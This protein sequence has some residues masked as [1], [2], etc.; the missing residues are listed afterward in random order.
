MPHLDNVLI[1][2]SGQI[3]EYREETYYSEIGDP[4]HRHISQLVGL[5]PGTQITELNPEWIKASEYTLNARGDESTGWSTM[6]RLLAWARIKN[7]SRA[8]DLLVTFIKNNVM[9]NLWDKHP[10][11]QIDGNFGYVAGVCEM[12]VQS[13]EGFID[14]LPTLSPRWINGSFKGIKAR[15]NFEISCT[16]KNSK[17]VHATIKSLSG[18]NLVLKNKNYAIYKNGQKIIN[19]DQYVSIK[20]KVNEIIEIKDK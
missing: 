18:N 11:F 5:Y 12:L 3:K 2:T 1:G 10:P 17:L 9:D 14:I 4:H 15:G 8:D 7:R 16:F 6:H 13:Q 20:T 19:C